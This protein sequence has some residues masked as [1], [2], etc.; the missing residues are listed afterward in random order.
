MNNVI[1]INGT[2][3]VPTNKKEDTYEDFLNQIVDVEELK[4]SRK[5][6][7]E[8]NFEYLQDLIFK[9]YQKG[10]E[11]TLLTCLAISTVKD[12]ICAT[13]NGNFEGV[14]SSG[15]KKRSQ[16]KYFNSLKVGDLTR[17]TLNRMCSIG[18]D[19]R[20]YQNADKVPN[21]WGT[22]Y[23]LTRIDDKTFNDA[24]TDGRINPTMTRREASILRYGWDTTVPRDVT[25][26]LN[27][28]SRNMER[29]GSAR[30]DYGVPDYL[31]KRAKKVGILY[32]CPKGAEHNYFPIEEFNEQFQAFVKVWNEKNESSPV[33]LVDA[34]NEPKA[35][36]NMLKFSKKIIN[37]LKNLDLN[38]KQL[39]DIDDS[40]Q[41]EKTRRF[42]AEFSKTETY[43]N[44]DGSV[45]VRR[46]DESKL[47]KSLFSKEGR[48]FALEVLKENGYEKRAPEKAKGLQKM[49]AGDPENFYSPSETIKKALDRW[50]Q[51]ISEVA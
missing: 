2:Q 11:S 45:K 14:G 41:P 16:E 10:K 19:K 47:A 25:S 36:A 29:S 9:Q 38:V 20:I 17:Q 44:K 32:L 39:D 21:G 7:T 23:E 18:K 6:G 8:K 27:T 48:N 24:I 34:F 5:L 1:S 28:P 31:A 15:D 35:V 13:A 43:K 30:T 12:E 3:R 42:F 51:K 4:A 46:L 49:F 50:N 22:L 37:D 40:K 33:I 26:G